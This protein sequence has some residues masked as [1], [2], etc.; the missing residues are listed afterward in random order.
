MPQNSL[1]QT[2]QQSSDYAELCNALY[3]REL[4]QLVNANLVTVSAMQSKL[5][6]LPHYIKR[7]AYSMTQVETPLIL[8]RQNAHWSTK[9]SK[10]M[11][12]SGQNPTLV[13]QW[14]QQFAVPLGLVVPI[15]FNDRILL[16]SIDRLDQSQPRIRTN[17]F[18]WFDANTLSKPFSQQ[19][20]AQINLQVQLLKPT[21]KVM[22][23]ACA[24]HRWQNNTTTTPLL[25]TLRELLLSCAIN[26]QNFKQAKQLK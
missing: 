25:L 14:Y 16:D 18:G 2:S 9:Q 13:W 6:S 15:W 5:K 7:T 19:G 8:D 17:A 12:L 10:I 22:M 4:Q 3:E 11:P 26:W 21:K 24:G 1:W 20:S 23:A